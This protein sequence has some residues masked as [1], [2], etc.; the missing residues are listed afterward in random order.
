VWSLAADEVFSA[1]P[2]D[3]SVPARHAGVTPHPLDADFG[4]VVRRVVWMTDG[5]RCS[6]MPNSGRGQ[7]HIH[8]LLGIFDRSSTAAMIADSTA[9][10]R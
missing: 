3:A 7:A 4:G 6:V 9:S 10:F 1:S 2:L 5:C 8:A